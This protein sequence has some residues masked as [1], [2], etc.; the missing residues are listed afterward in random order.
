MKE[1]RIIPGIILAASM[2]LGNRASAGIDASQNFKPEAKTQQTIELI[3]K[4]ENV[5]EAETAYAL[6]DDQGV[7]MDCA[8]IISLPNEYLAVYHGYIDNVFVGRL[9]KSSD[10]TNWNYINTLDSYASQLTIFPIQNGGYI[11]GSERNIFIDGKDAGSNL[12]FKYYK[13][14]ENLY[15]AQADNDFLIPRTKSLWNEGTPNVFSVTFENPEKPDIS[16]SSIEV[17]F[18]YNDTFKNGDREARGVLTNFSSWEAYEDSQIN[19][20]FESQGAIDIGDRTSFVFKDIPYVIY[21]ARKSKD[22]ADWRPYL[23]DLSSQTITML[24]LKTNKGSKSFANPTLQVIDDRF[25]S[26]QFLPFE[27]AVPDE[28]GV[29]LYTAS[30]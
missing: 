21:E 11:V 27:G 10:L 14:L 3:N 13:N 18:H 6:K 25:I 24:N 23:H 20:W 4:L 22:F 30:W 28:A 16:K 7:G 2:V 15:N 5:R 17:G 19:S 8:E 12:E 9:A 29:M 1:R 26:T